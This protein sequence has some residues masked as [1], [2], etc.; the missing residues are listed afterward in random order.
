MPKNKIISKYR[1]KITNDSIKITRK[2]CRTFK[3]KKKRC[4]RKNQQ[5]R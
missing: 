1:L 5:V 4:R 2:E 3:D